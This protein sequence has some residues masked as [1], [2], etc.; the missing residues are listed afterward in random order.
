MIHFEFLQRSKAT[1]PL[2]R[3]FSV[4]VLAAVLIVPMGVAASPVRNSE[5]A[6]I[7]FATFN[8]S[9]IATSPGSLSQTSPHPTTF[10]QGR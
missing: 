10:K 2:L 9:S 7:R 4:F 8:A 1:G 5:A 6:T 3:L